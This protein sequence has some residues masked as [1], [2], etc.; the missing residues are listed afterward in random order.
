MQ[1]YDI[2]KER[3]DLYATRSTDF[4]IIE[5]PPLHFLMGDGHGDPNTSTSYREAVE[6]LYVTSYSV[7]AVAKASLRRGTRSG[8]SKDCGPP[9]TWTPSAWATR[10][11]GTGL[12]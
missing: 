12:R 2:K 8:R 7:H 4:Q 9:T 3:K 10:M 1:T 5:V 11:R 6:A